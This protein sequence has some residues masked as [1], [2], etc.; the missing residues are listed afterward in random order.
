MPGT[1]DT[2]YVAVL[3]LA[4]L[5]ILTTLGGVALALY[6]GGRDRAV[7]LG[8]GFSAG[9]MLLVSLLE[10]IPEAAWSAGVGVAGL[11][12]ILGVGIVAALHWVIPH[13]HLVEEKGIFRPDLL[14][15]AY[16]V[17]FG[18]ILHDVPEGFAMANSYLASPSLGVLVAAAIALHNLPEE[19]AMAL[20]IVA[21]RAPR[22]LF[23]AALLSGLAEPAGALAG[24]VAVHIYPGLNAAFMAFAA[25]AMVFVSVHELLPMARRYGHTLLFFTGAGVSALVYGLLTAALPA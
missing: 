21:A 14:R 10:L 12:F 3:L 7:A 5:S 1:G 8:I 25:G 2:P 16:L 18:L 9:I 22:F 15:T 20:P 24:L 4:S 13:T 11:S 6:A 17:A 19:F 23:L